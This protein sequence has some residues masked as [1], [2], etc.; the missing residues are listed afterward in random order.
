VLFVVCSVF[1]ISELLN[2]LHTAGKVNED[3]VKT[4]ID[5]IKQNQLHTAAMVNNPN[6]VSIAVL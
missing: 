1:T 6:T 4:V 5:F 2:A 3:M